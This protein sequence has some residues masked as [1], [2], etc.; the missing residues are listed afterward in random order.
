MG[1]VKDLETF[2]SCA[3]TYVIQRSLSQIG[4]AETFLQSKLCSLLFE[5]FSTFNT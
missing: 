5:V 3:G 1:M 4:V 2:F